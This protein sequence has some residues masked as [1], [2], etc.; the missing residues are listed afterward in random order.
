MDFRYPLYTHEQED[1]Q[2]CSDSNFHV[3]EISNSWAAGQKSGSEEEADVGKAKLLLQLE[4]LQAYV[5]SLE[6]VLHNEEE[7]HNVEVAVV[8]REVYIHGC[9][10]IAPHVL[11]KLSD[12][13]MA[14]YSE[15]TYTCTCQTFDQILGL[16]LLNV[17]CNTHMHV[18]ELAI[19]IQNFSANQTFFL[20]S[21]LSHFIVHHQHSL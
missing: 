15:A 6:N 19:Y 1:Q 8:R 20:H 18:G 10:K 11:A 17:T 4:I 2:E 9:K 21:T 12:K 16:Q 14:K 3:A 5:S 7:Q 13:V